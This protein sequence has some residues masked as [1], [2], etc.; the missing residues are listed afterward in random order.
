[1]DPEELFSL[2]AKNKTISEQ[3][4]YKLASFLNE[5]DLSDDNQLFCYDDIYEYLVVIG[6][7]KQKKF[8][9]A[10][11]RFLHCKDS[12][13]V[14]LVLEI[15]CLKWED[16]DDYLE[17]IIG[18]ALGCPWDE[19]EDVRQMAIKILGEYLF[20]NKSTC[21]L[22]SNNR[23]IISLLFSIFD[24]PL[25]PQW[26]RQ[27]A[28]FALCRAAG[29]KWEEVPPECS[30]LNFEQECE[31]IDQNMLKHLREVSL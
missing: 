31:K 15:L 5:I 8:R 28:Y 20:K 26:T 12:L 13:T 21:S 16:I 17:L 4:L 14:S 18:F 24:N 1:M 6:K 29:K 2:L 30:V 25:V 22:P 3:E 27:S 9:F 19:D 11:E 10:L 23:Q 7:S